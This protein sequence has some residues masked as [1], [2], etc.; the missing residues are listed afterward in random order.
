MSSLKHC[1]GHTLSFESQ[2]FPAACSLKNY[3]L[4]SG[5]KHL[6]NTFFVN[7]NNTLRILAY[8]NYLTLEITVNFQTLL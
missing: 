3:N 1:L 2:K 6:Y 4:S 7:I 5:P 8:Y